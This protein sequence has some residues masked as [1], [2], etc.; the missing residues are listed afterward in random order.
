MMQALKYIEFDHVF[1]EDEMKVANSLRL[2]CSL[3]NAACKLRIGEY[4]EASRL[5]SKVS[6]LHFFMY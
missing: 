4:V 3:N 2:T 5:C 1:N 6:L